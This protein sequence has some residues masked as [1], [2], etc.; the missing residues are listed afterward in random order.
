[1]GLIQHWLRN[2][3]DKPIQ[4]LAEMIIDLIDDGLRKS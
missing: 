4:E 1:M 2:N 3:M